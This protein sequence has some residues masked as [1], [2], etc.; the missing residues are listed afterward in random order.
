MRRSTPVIGSVHL[1]VA[2]LGEDFQHAALDADELKR[3]GASSADAVALAIADI[4][5]RRED[6]LS[7][8]LVSH[9]GSFCSWRA[10]VSGSGPACR[11][12]G[13]NS[14]SARSSRGRR[15]RASTAGCLPTPAAVS[16]SGLPMVSW[17]CERHDVAGELGEVELRHRALERGADLLT[18]RGRPCRDDARLGIAEIA[19]LLGVARLRDGRGLVGEAQFQREAAGSMRQVSLTE[20]SP[21]SSSTRVVAT[22]SVRASNRP[23]ASLRSEMA[24][25]WSR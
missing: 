7:L 3:H 6:A 13:D 17:P 8:G 25:C 10:A 22:G 21:R 19:F 9:G 14:R 18:L 1:A 4:A 16:R 12:S 2:R 11:R 23:A 15:R 20:A 24:R 5:R